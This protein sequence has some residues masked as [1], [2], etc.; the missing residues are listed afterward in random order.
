M[1]P[2]RISHV[3]CVILAA[4]AGIHASL[5][6][7]GFPDGTF[8]G[9]HTHS[10]GLTPDGTRLLALN[11]PDGRLSVFDI[12]N[13]ANPAPVLVAEIP[14]GLEPVA[15]R[16]RTND[17]V[18][19]VNEVGDCVSVV[20]LSLGVAV[21]TLPAEDEPADVVFAQGKAFVS[22][23]RNNMLRVFDATTRQPLPS[24]PMEGLHPRALATDANGT[25]VFAAFLLSGNGTTVL[26]AAQAPAP[27]P[28]TN[29]ALPPAPQTALIV[30]ADDPRITYSVLDRDVAEVNAVTGQVTRYLGGVGTNL[31]DIAIQPGTGNPWVANT[32]SRNLVRFEPVLRGHVADHRITRLDAGSGAA[33]V[34]DLNPGIDYGLLPNPAAQASA[35]AQP[36]A[37]SFSADGSEVWVAAFGSDRVARVNAATGAVTASVNLRSTGETS[38]KMRGPRALALSEATQRLYVLNRISNTVTVIGMVGGSVL[39]EVPLGS[40][41]PTPAP[42]REGRGFL[43]DARLS[44]NG[45]ISCAT[46]HVDAD[47]DGLAWDLGNPGGDLA[48]VLG[49]NLTAGDPT[50]R[51]RTVHPMKGPMLTQPLKALVE[52]AP[53]QRRGDRPTIEDFNPTFD[54]LMGGSPL[55]AADITLLASY[56]TSVLPHPNPNRLGGDTLPATFLG[57]DPIHGEELFN[58]PVNRCADCH[59]DE[60]A[61][62][63]NIDLPSVFGFSQPI[64]NPSLRTVYQRLFFNPQPGANSLSGFGLAHDGAGGVHARPGLSPSD[65]LDLDAFVQC[66]ESGV[67]P[68][69]GLGATFNAQNVTAAAPLATVA[70]LEEQTVDFAI[71]LV[72]QGVVGGRRRAYFYNSSTQLYRPD[73]AAEPALSRAGLLALLSGGDTITFLGVPYGRGSRLGGD[74]DSDAVL[75]GDEPTPSLTVSR[76]GLNVH[77]QWPA[78]PA[79]WV[80]ESTPDLNDQWQVVTHPHTDDGLSIQTAD[81]VGA[82]SARFYRLRRTW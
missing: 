9:R 37:L 60:S 62:I 42:I 1:R 72:V 32:E 2:C 65:I 13:P 49:A 48:T 57:A 28:P 8:E 79:G 11:T 52:G 70:V 44:G 3:C 29:P 63:N 18:W 53:F 41:N 33:T 82:A 43:F 36:T 50:L 66:I 73:V 68:A 26:P 61:G 38:R 64:K 40:H 47:V 77:L 69:V 59:A 6:G 31:F 5:F 14:V 24:I 23:S 67:P 71:E 39:A 22:C 19:V 12:A 78:Q 35:F 17:E 51:P 16:A 30:P 10:I 34:F 55:A 4:L 46:C 75:D 45:T 54:T 21:A 76:T 25:H 80:L 20:S 58:N 7:H 81:P 74:R 15:L 56:V 27:P